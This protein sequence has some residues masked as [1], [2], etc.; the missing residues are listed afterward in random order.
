MLVSTEPDIA[1]P[2]P[3]FLSAGQASNAEP[4]APL[5]MPS[6]PMT[7]YLQR[8]G[9]LSRGLTFFLPKTLL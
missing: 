1:K 3:T 5:S 2:Q 9:A 6:M 8:P 4:T 7:E